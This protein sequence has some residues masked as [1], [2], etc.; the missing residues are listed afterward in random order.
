[1]TVKEAIAYGVSRDGCSDI[2]IIGDDP[3]KLRVAGRIESIDQ[4]V[5]KDGIEAFIKEFLDEKKQGQ[6]RGH[7]ACD[8]MAYVGDDQV[9]VHAHKEHRGIRLALRLTRR[10]IPK[11][12]KLGLPSEIAAW[13]ERSSGLILVCGPSG[14]G[15]TTLLAALV[16]RL[17]S[18][19]RGAI[20]TIERPV[21]YVHPQR[22]LYVSQIEVGRDTQS[23]ESGSRAALQSDPDVLMIGEVNDPESAKV[24]MTATET[25]HLVLA[26]MHAQ[27]AILAL[28]R[29]ATWGGQSGLIQMSHSLIGIVALR[30]VPGVDGDIV[31][32]AEV[33]V[34]ND[35]IRKM[36]RE[37]RFH[38]I[39]QVME[40]DES[41]RTLANDLKRLVSEGRIDLATAKRFAPRQEDM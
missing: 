12:E 7:G 6:L 24:M 28:D 27:D 29:I 30:L 37:E 31:P 5:S 40:S 17:N 15:K 19:D 8:T 13:T 10:T 25:G 3:V 20:V 14:S 23:F 21:E 9:R 38:Q 39:R 32:A 11:I 34:M 18:P 35:A 41:M 36:I 4:S 2:H 16:N 22:G 33:L 1:M 26:S